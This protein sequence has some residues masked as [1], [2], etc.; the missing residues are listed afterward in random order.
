MLPN[1]AG[2]HMSDEVQ[3]G[4]LSWDGGRFGEIGIRDRANTTVIRL[5]SFLFVNCVYL[6][7]H[8]LR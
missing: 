5:I 2:L 8:S 4:A 6:L 1:L 7:S 3:I